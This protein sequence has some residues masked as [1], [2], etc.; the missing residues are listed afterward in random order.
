M[1]MSTI[2]S[3]LDF[4]EGLKNCVFSV[5]FQKNSIFSENLPPEDDVIDENWWQIFLT[6][7]SEYLLM[8]KTRH[9]FSDC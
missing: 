9:Q 6:Q 2:A 1:T 8:L 3:S 7:D 4:W 5:L